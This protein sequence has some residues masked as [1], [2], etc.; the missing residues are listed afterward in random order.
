MTRSPRRSRLRWLA[1]LIIAAIVVLAAYDGRYALRGA[2]FDLTGEENLFS[3]LKGLTDLSAD[4]LRPRLNL[5]PEAPVKYANLNPFGVNVFL[6]EE[7][8]PAKRE[9]TVKLAK[10]AGFY[11]LRQE[12]PWQDIEIH[13][14][15]DFEDRRNS[16]ARSAWEKY[17][18]IVDLADRYD[19]ELIVRI[20]TPPAW[21][22]DRGD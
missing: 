6:N 5:A 15:G 8:E 14:K 3:Q 19:M 20:S 16:P 9:Q 2:L 12:F 1:W 22:R 4:L 21:S 11:W 17:D 13:A 18:Q 10:E 7:V